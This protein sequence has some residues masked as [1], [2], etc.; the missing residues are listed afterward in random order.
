MRKLNCLVSA[1]VAIWAA[2]SL[3]GELAF[4]VE[5][6]GLAQSHAPA[7]AEASARVIAILDF[8]ISGNSVLPQEAIEAAVMPFLGPDRSPDDLDL[9]RQALERAYQDRGYQAVAVTVLPDASEDGVVRL[10]VTEAQ[11][12]R[13]RVVGA[14]YTTISSVKALAPSLTPGQVPNFNAVQD[15]IVALNAVPDRTITPAI[16]AGQEPNTI[17]VNLV[18]DD[19]LPYSASLELNNSYSQGTAPLRLVG[20]AGYN[21]L[22][23]LGHSFNL[24][25][26]FAPQ[27]PSGTKVFTGSYLAPLTGTPWTIGLNGFHSDS[28]V[29]TGISGSIAGRGDGIGLRA[30][31]TLPGDDQFFE[32]MSF[33]FDWKSYDE[34]TNFDTISSADSLTGDV[35]P[36]TY[37]PVSTSYQATW[38][39]GDTTATNL[40]AGVTFGIRGLGA[41]I[42]DFDRKRYNAR[43][44]FIY[45][46]ASLDRTQPLP[47]GFSIYG[48]LDGMVANQP[49]VDNE[50]FTAGGYDSVRGYLEAEV[51]GDKALHGSVELRS[52][53]IAD[54]I[55]ADINDLHF[56]TFLEGAKLWLIDALPEQQSNYRLGSFGAGVRLQAYDDNFLFFDI[57]QTV[58]RAVTTPAGARS[59]HFR[60]WRQF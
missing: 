21:N 19:K 25:Y 32:S 56:V 40:F 28:N 30:N 26:E 3:N 34:S 39:D 57:A 59:L 48:I 36:L 60:V 49:L 51:V 14:K 2:L 53:S 10:Q 55:Y 18:V 22:W 15:D 42:S 47:A 58:N 35:V 20:K 50:Q 1:G 16:V 17:D 31:L 24:S 29:P 11:V 4:A 41:S 7:P 54:L 52:P 46:R 5:E 23:Q 44:N 13:V 45:L 9:A 12:G 8:A 37:F 33:G 43:G 38:K 27:N 6:N